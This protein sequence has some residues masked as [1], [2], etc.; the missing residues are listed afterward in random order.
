MCTHMHG[1]MHT[2]NHLIKYILVS[3]TGNEKSTCKALVISVVLELQVL[4][5]LDVFRRNFRILS[6]HACVQ[7]SC[8][9]CALKVRIFILCLVQPNVVFMY[10]K[11]YIVPFE[12]PLR[13]ILLIRSGWIHI[14]NAVEFIA[15]QATYLMALAKWIHAI[16]CHFH[17]AA[18]Q[19]PVRSEVCFEILAPLLLLSQLGYDKCY[20]DAVSGKFMWWERGLAHALVSRGQEKWRFQCFIPI[21][22]SRVLA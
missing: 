21:T 4:W 15:V 17:K 6:G 7:N 9:F 2:F 18:V 19:I 13:G 12:E 1:C 22:P 3:Q 11:G 10:L 5:H 20:N 16:I 8:I 14:A